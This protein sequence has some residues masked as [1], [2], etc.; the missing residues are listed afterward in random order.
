[1]EQSVLDHAQ[2]VIG[3]VFQDPILL[4]RALTHASNVEQRLHSNERLE[5]LGDAVLGL[6]VCD[7]VY[8]QY[9][10]LLEGEMTKIKSLAVSRQTCAT[11]SQ[12]LGFHKLLIL[13]K[14]MQGTGEMPTSLA[15]AAFESI[16]GAIFLDGGFTAA[17]RFV[18]PHVLAIIEKAAS[19]GHQHNFKSALQQYAQ[20]QLDA[21]P[22]YRVVDEQGPDH[23]KCFR[24]AVEL[25]GRRFEA[26]WGQSK[27]KAEQEA[28]LMALRELGL[29]IDEIGGELR[30]QH[31]PAAA[32][33]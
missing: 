29:V 30:L 5:F 22:I 27:K 17:E 8:R 28:A 7:L 33:N 12:K 24:V 16:I 6:V 32:D 20:Q 3:Y 25:N 9:P 21:S 14:G 13:G 2:S 19:S 15:A 4:E 10:S 18:R 11:I 1:M 26:C 23:A 31:S